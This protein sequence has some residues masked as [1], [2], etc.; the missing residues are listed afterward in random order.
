LKALMLKMAKTNT[1]TSGNI[2]GLTELLRSAKFLELISQLNDFQT[3]LNTLSS[4][5][6]RISDSLNEEPDL[7]A[8]KFPRLQARIT[9]IENTQVTMQ[10]DISSIKGMVTE[11]FQAF[12]GLS[13]STFLEPEVENV[14]KEPEVEKKRSIGNGY[15][16]KGQKIK[17][18]RTKPSTEWKSM[19]KPKSNQSKSQES[20]SQSQSRSRK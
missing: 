17:Q 1:A 20:Q 4:E 3:L 13:S 5:C 9:T 18:K 12:K 19:E 14:E 2:T 10:A 15:P 8:I 11:M 7:K 6:L 16:T